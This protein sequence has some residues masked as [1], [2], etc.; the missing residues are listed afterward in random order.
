[1]AAP[2][3][4]GYRLGWN[5]PNNV[6]DPMGNFEVKQ[7][8]IDTKVY[9]SDGYGNLSPTTAGIAYSASAFSSGGP[10]FQQGDPTYSGGTLPTATVTASRAGN[11]DQSAT[12]Y[13]YNGSLEDYQKEYGFE[14]VA[15]ENIVNFWVQ[16]HGA[17]FDNY[18]ATQDQAEA[19][20]IAVQKM[21]M[22]ALGIST[23][24]AMGMA[25]LSP[26]LSSPRGFNFSSPVI[27]QPLPVH[28]N[29]LSSLKPTWGYQLYSNNGFFLKNGIT[30]E[31]IPQAR[32]T[33][34]FM[35]DKHMRNLQLFPNRRAAWKWEYQ[36]NLIQRGPLNRN[37][38]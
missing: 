14:G 32:Y 19:A 24:G 5:Q 36:Q 4:T 10:L 22:F 33:K 15:Y 12:R 20:R 38:H 1:M 23:A 29:S 35:A 11:Y 13:G 37:M 6:N 25:G 28:G 17:A 26:S 30:S 21:Q 9:P 7:T 34:A 18:V 8:G 2:G 27:S 31:A 3:W 16:V